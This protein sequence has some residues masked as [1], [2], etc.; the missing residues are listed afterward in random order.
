M[1]SPSSSTVLLHPLS[2][3]RSSF[4][5][6]CLFSNTMI[7]FDISHSILEINSFSEIASV[8]HHPAVF[9]TQSGTFSDVLELDVS[10]IIKISSLIKN[11]I[12]LTNSFSEIASV[13]HHPAV[14]FTQS[15]TA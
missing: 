5:N 6:P 8:A 3:T 11:S 13:A 14:F 15:G 1:L 7:P 10:L 2:D 9:F 12:A 4:S